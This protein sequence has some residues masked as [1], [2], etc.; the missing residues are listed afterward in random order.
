MFPFLSTF[1]CIGD[2]L[3]ESTASNFS[4]LGSKRHNGLLPPKPENHI[5]PSLASTIA[6]TNPRLP[7]PALGKGYDLAVLV[8]GSNFTKSYD[9][10]PTV[11]TLPLP[12]TIVPLGQVP[13][14]SLYS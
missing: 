2:A 7:D 5:E 3:K 13:L 8:A 4:R 14:D 6:Q 11:H 10:D 1:I 9:R 12:S